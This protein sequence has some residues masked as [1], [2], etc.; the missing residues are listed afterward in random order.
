M[1]KFVPVM[2]DKFAARYV[3]HE[4]LPFILN[5]FSRYKDILIDDYY[6]KDPLDLISHL[7]DEVNQLYPWFLVVVKNDAP[8]GV[9]WVTHWH[10]ADTSSQTPKYHSCQIHSYMDKKFWG[11]PTKDALK[12]LLNILFNQLGVERVQMEIPDFNHKACA[13]AKRMGFTQEGIVRCATIKNGKPV[14][15]VLFGIL[16]GEVIDKVA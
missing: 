6:P 16:K 10:G 13:F 15:N 4:Y 11:K 12:E 1:I 5:L 7:I 9:V 8:I 2:A 3:N 14:N